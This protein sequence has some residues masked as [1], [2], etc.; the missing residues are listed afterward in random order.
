LYSNPFVYDGISA[1]NYFVGSGSS[2]GGDARM[3]LTDSTTAFTNSNVTL[4]SNGNVGLGAA[5]PRDQLRVSKQKK[6]V[7]TGRVDKGSESKQE[8]VTEFGTFN[9]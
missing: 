2:T 8:F 9:A 4:T 7:E 1:G 3:L 5:N 6:S